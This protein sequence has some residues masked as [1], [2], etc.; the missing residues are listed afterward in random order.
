M[1]NRERERERERERVDTASQHVLLCHMTLSRSLSHS[2]CVH[3][4]SLARSAEAL[5]FLLLRL[6]LSLCSLLSFFAL[7]LFTS[8]SFRDRSSITLFPFIHTTLFYHSHPLYFSLSVS[9]TLFPSSF[10][11]SLSLACVFS[12]SP[13]TLLLSLLLMACL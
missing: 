7:S 11:S 8:F 9:L 4:R 1:R 3:A 12:V 10:F 13:F 6:F 2:V 5:V